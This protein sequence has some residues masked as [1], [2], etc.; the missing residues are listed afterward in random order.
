LKRQTNPGHQQ[1]RR[2]PAFFFGVPMPPQTLSADHDGL[3]F[4]T[5]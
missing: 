5:P 1:R 4:L 2:E 3:A